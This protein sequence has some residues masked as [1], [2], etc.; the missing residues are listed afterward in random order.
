MEKWCPGRGKI[1][2]IIFHS[3]LPREKA[4]A[5]GSSGNCMRLKWEPDVH[6]EVGCTGFS[7]C[8]RLSSRLGGVAPNKP[9]QG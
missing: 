3:V 4:H 1:V 8:V 5:N 2:K 6:S 9:L 7:N